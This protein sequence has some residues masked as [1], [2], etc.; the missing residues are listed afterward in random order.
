MALKVAGGGGGGDNANDSGADGAH[1][2]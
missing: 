1:W 2:T